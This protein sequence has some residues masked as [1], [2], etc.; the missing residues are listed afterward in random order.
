[1]AVDARGL[2][3]PA[4]DLL[5]DG[6]WLGAVS[7]QD[8]F[9]G[10]WITYFPSPLGAL[11]FGREM[12]VEGEWKPGTVPQLI[13]PV[14]SLLTAPRLTPGPDGAVLSLG[15]NGNFRLRP[16]L[17]LAALPGVAPDIFNHYFALDG[18]S[19]LETGTDLD[20]RPIAKRFASGTTVPEV[21]MLASGTGRQQAPSLAWTDRGPQVVFQV[22]GYGRD[23]A[24]QI[25]TGFNQAVGGKGG[26]PITDPAFS[27]ASQAWQGNHLQLVT[28]RQEHQGTLG[29]GDYLDPD[30]VMGQLFTADQGGV[31]TR[32]GPA[33]PLASGPGSQRG[34]AVAPFGTGFLAAWREETT[35]PFPASYTSSIR[36]AFVTPEGTVKPPG[37]KLLDISVGELS[38]VSVAGD[39][40]VAWKYPQL[41]EGRTGI[42]TAQIY[43]QFPDQVLTVRQYRN[44]SPPGHDAVSPQVVANAGAFVV[45][46][47]D[48]ITHR[49]FVSHLTDVLKGATPVSPAGRNAREP[50][51]ANLSPGVTAVFWL[52][53]RISWVEIW[54]V[55]LSDGGVS[56]PSMVTKG[57]FDRD[58]LVA[59]GDGQ[60]RVV[61]GMLDI[62]LETPGLKLLL[63][64]PQ[65]QQNGG[66][67]ISA[68]GGGLELSWDTS[69]LF[70]N[71][72]SLVESS[73]DLS[74]WDRPGTGST[75]TQMSG[76]TR[77]QLPLPAST[78]SQFF[79]LE[80][81]L[82]QG[83]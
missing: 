49:I 63:V 29:L 46:W 67:A 37:G 17:P 50:A 42:R 13:A 6:N 16:G 21:L 56:E 40:L 81:K 12:T 34:V 78:L 68:V 9:Y 1:M 51:L 70:P 57:D 71:D 64:A 35:Q 28:Y 59:S 18:T 19:V 3:S 48:K 26:W 14:G 8:G 79:R 53:E 33:F 83:Q 20:G 65:I 77:L 5:S 41:G 61:L 69:V 58:T 76:R 74:H 47:R 43:N 24:S 54:M 10:V 75:P 11:V 44:P 31:L 60:C 32:T 45:A 27:T 23:A 22:D 80:A 73:M 4:H 2:A 25:I 15:G 52:E 55:T 30:D 39:G 66:L 82:T 38:A 36:A 72:A 7:Y 62:S